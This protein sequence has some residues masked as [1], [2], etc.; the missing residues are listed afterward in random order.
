[1][2]QTSLNQ[3]KDKK[4]SDLVSSVRNNAD[5]DSFKEICNRY[6]DVFYKV[7]QGYF[8][9]LQNS[10]VNPKDIFEEKNM[11]ILNCIKTFNPDKKAKLSTWIGNCA[12]YLC[13]NSIHS[14]KL[15][16]PSCTEDVNE[17][18]ENSQQKENFTSASFLKEEFEYII[19]LLEQI[20]D[21][22]IIE[23][24]NLRYFTDSKKMV[25]YKIAKKMN[26]ST[27]TAINLHN[28]GISILRGKFNS[29]NISDLI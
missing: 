21:K 8:G 9:P 20:K 3:L 25:W 7:C 26:I 13:L 15:I 12:R 23:V 5:D 27:Q 28:K 16:L 10:G 2:Y 18:I 6:E 1:M 17:Q 11:I 22:R 19:N 4:D 24:F 14:R 29:K